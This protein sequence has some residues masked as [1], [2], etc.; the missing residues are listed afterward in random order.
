MALC[1]FDQLFG[2][3]IRSGV[4]GLRSLVNK[5][6]A[7]VRP[8]KQ[9][10]LCPL[11]NDMLQSPLKCSACKKP[12]CEYCVKESNSCPHCKRTHLTTVALS[13]LEQELI[14]E[15]EFNCDQC[16]ETV[17]YGDKEA[18]VT[19]SCSFIWEINLKCPACEASIQGVH[20]M[21]KHLLKLCKKTQRTCACCSD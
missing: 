21:K 17:L 18:H 2:D 4:D 19:Q 10:F 14:D 8:V 12:F 20:A 7:V 11:C 16:E 13:P 3:V 5:K 1:S 15:L 9:R 6:S